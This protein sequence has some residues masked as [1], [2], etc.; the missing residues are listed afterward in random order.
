[1][2]L[3][4]SD[5]SKRISS[6]VSVKRLYIEEFC[7]AVREKVVWIVLPWHDTFSFPE[8]ELMYRN[9]DFKRSFSVYT[10]TIMERA[11]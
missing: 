1:M 11:I 10:F 7:W 5:Q 4:N 3:L 6:H 2:G 9:M 8:D